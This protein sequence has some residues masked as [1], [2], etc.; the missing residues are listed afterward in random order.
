MGAAVGI[1]VAILAAALLAL[2]AQLQNQGASKV[3]D[4][5]P[6]GKRF[7]LEQLIALVSTPRWLGGSTILGIAVA[8]QL[9]SLLFAPIAVVQPIGALSLVITVLL[10]TRMNRAH[11]PRKAIV[12][13]GLCL[14]GVTAFVV[15]ASFTT[16]SGS[17]TPV[18]VGVVL[19]VLGVV[20]SVLGVVLV[21]LRGRRSA[22][23]L[24]LAAGLLFGFVATLA[25][26]VIGRVSAIVSQG[27]GFTSAD[28]LTLL[29]VVALLV[30]GA[31]GLSLVQGA[32]A[33][34]SPDL[35]VAALTVIDPLVAVTIGIALL[36]EAAKAPGWAFAV[37]VVAEAVAIVG[38]LRLARH[39]PEPGTRDD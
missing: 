5:T 37:F 3:D 27:T 19:A 30:A 34:G 17:P 28:W 15:T 29:C 7:G 14:A 1:P 21:L 20:L 26:L 31:I 18:A 8:L 36:G 10:D 39:Q 24:A 9:V 32:Y 38:V 6:D 4:D 23:R 12:A 25:K 11:I 35:V 22:L 33:A 16:T 13:I 2:G